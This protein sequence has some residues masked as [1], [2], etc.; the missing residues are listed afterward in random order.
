[1]IDRSII[2]TTRNMCWIVE[3]SPPFERMQIQFVPRQIQNSRTADLAPVK[4]VGRNHPRYHF[5]GGQEVLR[6]EMD[7]LSQDEAR[8]EGMAKVRWLKSLTFNEGNTSPV[9]RVK[10][11]MG[12]LYR[13]LEFVVSSVTNTPQRIDHNAFMYPIQIGVS[14]DFI[15][16]QRRNLT[17]SQVRRFP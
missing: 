7:F 14:V 2:S 16:D 10:V 1:M 15:V 6:L 13:G 17:R 11:V 9:P 12:R 5:V 3:L 4:I 8:I